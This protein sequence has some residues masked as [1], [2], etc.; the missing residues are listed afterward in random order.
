MLAEEEGRDTVNFYGGNSDQRIH[1]SSMSTSSI[2]VPPPPTDRFA[3]FTAEPDRHGALPLGARIGSA[4][5]LIWLACVLTFGRLF[6]E[7]GVAPIYIADVL[8]MSGTLLSLPQWWPVAVKRGLRGLL[9]IAVT[10]AGLT[11][12]S[13]YRGLEAGYP[14]AL[15][16]ACMG[17]YPIVGVAIAGLV[18]R[19][20]D[21][22]RQFARRVMPLVPIGFLII[23]LSGGSFIAASIG[24]YLSC[25]AAWAAAPGNARRG[26]VGILTLVAGCYLAESGA[27]RGPVLAIL[28]AVVAT[29]VAAREALSQHRGR[30]LTVAAIYCLSVA[31]I[32]ASSILLVNGSGRLDSKELLIFGP[33]VSRVLAS[34]QPDTESAN[35]VA[36][37]QAMWRYALSTTAKENPLFGRGSGRPIESGLG[38]SVTVDR[39]SGVHNSFIG[40]AFYMG[41]PAAILVVTAFVLAAVRC[42][43]YR[44]LPY[45]APLLGAAVAAVTTSMTNVALE[46][47]YIAGPSWAILGAA[48]GSAVAARMAMQDGPADPG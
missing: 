12:Q 33:V 7:I 6:S 14:S 15:K 34:T 20:P 1:V 42:W 3:G 23:G 38:T 44:F 31:L 47:P 5:L 46:T 37:R 17:V 32:G 36:L 41:F 48:A 19:N 25:A 40:Y 39:K 21:I 13:L 18:V 26:T 24:L 2:T 9:L 45:F 4:L 8:A 11:V 10:L 43:Q 35:N 22:V 30:R 29:R 27:R 16:S 28:L